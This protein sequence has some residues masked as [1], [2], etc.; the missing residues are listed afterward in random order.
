LCIPRVHNVDPEAQRLHEEGRVAGGKGDYDTVIALFTKAAARDPT[1]PYP[2]YDR[3]FM[4]LLKQKFDAALVDYR[5]TLELS[6]LGYFVA[7]TAAD[8]L[9]REREG[10]FPP[11]LYAAFAMLENMTDEQERRRD[12]DPRSA[13]RL[14]R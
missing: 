13:H 1:W 8:L 2:V 7:A 12:G 3:A 9:T 11:G 6:P 10:E 14:C 5:K 4:H